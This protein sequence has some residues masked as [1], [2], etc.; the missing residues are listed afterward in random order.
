MRD[1]IMKNFRMKHIGMLFAFVFLFG[2]IGFT[3]VGTVSTITTY[4]DEEEDYPSFSKMSEAAAEY[5]SKMLAPSSSGSGK[6]AHLTNTDSTN[7]ANLGGMVGYIDQ[8]SSV[9]QWL[10]SWLTT[11]SSKIGYTTY[12]GIMDEYGTPKSGIYYYV[13]YGA[14][15]KAMGL[16]S[17]GTEGGGKLLRTVSGFSLY[18][19]YSLS[20]FVPT[21]FKVAIQALSALNPFQV[22]S[23]RGM[24]NILKPTSTVTSG[25]MYNIGIAMTDFYSTLAEY[26]WTICAPIFLA[27]LILEIYLFKKTKPSSAVKKFIIRICA[28]GMGIPLLG[29]TYTQMLNMLEMSLDAGNSASTLVVSSILVDFEN[30]AKNYRLDWISSSNLSVNCDSS[31][32]TIAL[33]SSSIYNQRK[34]CYDINKQ[35]NGE[36]GLATYTGI[37][38]VS[39]VTG[40]LNWNTN[41][42]NNAQSAATKSFEACQ[43]LI[44]RYWDCD[45]YTAA[46]WESLVKSAVSKSSDAGRDGIEAEMKASDTEEEVEKYTH[47]FTAA[48]IDSTS[49]SGLQQRTANIWGLGAIKCTQGTESDG[50]AT[51][52]YSDGG[53]H[54]GDSLAHMGYNV[55]GGASGGLSHMSLYNYLNTSFGSGSLTMYS[56][57]DST[58]LFTREQHRS[59]NLIGGN[60]FLSIAYWLNAVTLLLSF[61]VIGFVYAI[62]MLF[63]IISRSIRML[64]SIPGMLLGSIKSFGKVIVYTICMI[65]QVLVTM[66]MYEIT[67]MMLYQVNSII[68]VPIAQAV[69]TSATITIGNT[70]LNVPSASVGLLTVLLVLGSVMQIIFV[71]FAIK[72]RK[73]I[74]KG[75]NEAAEQIIDKLLDTNAAADNSATMAQKAAGA[76]GALGGAY[77]GAKLAGGGSGSKKKAE[78]G[79]S[80]EDTA[81]PEDESAGTG[82]GDETPDATGSGGDSDGTGSGGIEGEEAAM[83]AEQKQLEDK[84]SDQKKVEEKKDSDS[85]DHKDAESSDSDSSDSQE[86]SAGEDGADGSDGDGGSDSDDGESNEPATDE[87]IAAEA[88]GADSLADM[89]DTSGGDKDSSDGD[90]GDSD[91][92]G[93][94]EGGSSA[95]DGKAELA[96]AES[97]HGGAPSGSADGKSTAAG[98]AGKAAANERKAKAQD[99]ANKASAEAGKNNAGSQQQ[100]AGAKAPQASADQKQGGHS[101]SY[102]QAKAQAEARKAQAQSTLNKA[103]AEAGKNNVGGQPQTGGTKPVSPAGSSNSNSS[104]S[105]S[106]NS[107]SNNSGS[108][109][110]Q[111]SMA[112]QVMG[113]MAAS[114]IAS[115]VATALGADEATAAKAGQ[116]A[117]M[118]A[119]SAQIANMNN[120]NNNGGGTA[121]N[122]GTSNA[123]ATGGSATSAPAQNSSTGG[124][125]GTMAPKGSTGGGTSAPAPVRTGGSTAPAG[126]GGSSVAAS[127]ATPGGKAPVINSSGGQAV[128]NSSASSSLVSNGGATNVNVQA[129]GGQKSSQQN[130]P[131]PGAPMTAKVGNSGPVGNSAP[132]QQSGHNTT[133]TGNSSGVGMDQSGLSGGMTAEEAAE[134]AQINRE[135]MQLEKQARMAL[136]SK[137]AIG[138][139]VNSIQA[140]PGVAANTV[141]TGVGTA[142][143]TVKTGVNNTVTG[144]KTTV[145][146]VTT[147]VTG[148][149][150]DVKSYSQSSARS[151]AMKQQTREL[152]QYVKYEAKKAKRIEKASK[153]VKGDYIQ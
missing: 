43:S 3:A 123:P 11:A 126:R 118:G 12:N 67:T 35:V 30:W 8:D 145:N 121:S 103:N 102:Q 125:S 17:T 65:L 129:N 138:R 2:L 52:A 114:A 63:Y 120:N 26:G 53:F 86:A 78:K 93:S 111:A 133:S 134:I 74:L 106:N 48:N 44:K 29:A 5:L 142:V 72:E 14:A 135:A 38:S 83:K 76:L 39:S 62:G 73:T 21:M 96:A 71:I 60:G 7:W 40:A 37:G 36:L 66:I 104:S 115:G 42:Y 99:A 13:Q 20:G 79:D 87:D 57:T 50:I 89:S 27:A 31:D 151:K 16:D 122:N 110:Q 69:N 45:T 105:S 15:L 112:R 113:T 77:A 152:D 32:G 59:V 141:K 75:F 18:V 24:T 144:V 128:V 56:T 153:G 95:S 49:V 119:M 150:N 88:A 124:S 80:L 51:Y 146:N 55:C 127:A 47:M 46:D 25:V 107:G 28:I 137:S 116:M 109:Q 84:S 131:A 61:T 139:T 4:A 1:K 108:Q 117:S 58:S 148:A 34:I 91:S 149:V 97:S 82:G 64:T 143:N 6:V 130:A 147:N 54:V 9:G 33:S 10:T 81:N 136:R 132:Q 41:L 90:S 92:A 22:F 70:I 85:S 68:T 19:L 100:Q 94:T 140:A 98:E 101:A 23:V